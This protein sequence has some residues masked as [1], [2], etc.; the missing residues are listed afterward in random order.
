MQN[1]TLSFTEISKRFIEQLKP[2]L[3][4]KIEN[5]IY[6][7]KNNICAGNCNPLVNY[8]M[9]EPPEDKLDNE[10]MNVLRFN[11][12]ALGTGEEE[13]IFAINKKCLEEKLN[14]KYKPELFSYDEMLSR[15]RKSN[16]LVLPSFL[17][18]AFCSFF[19]SDFFDERQ[20]LALFFYNF[21]K[22]INCE[23][24]LFKRVNKFCSNETKIIKEED[25]ALLFGIKQP[26]F[27]IIISKALVQPVHS[28][29]PSLLNDMQ[30]NEIKNFI[31]EMNLHKF[32]VTYKIVR[33]FIFYNFHILY[34]ISG[35][36]YVVKKLHFKLIRTKFILDRRC[37]TDPKKIFNYYVELDKLLEEINPAFLYNFD[38]SGVDEFVDR[39]KVMGLVPSDYE[40]T[41]VHVLKSRDA[42]KIS[43]L[44]CIALDGEAIGASFI[45]HSK[46]IAD[47]LKS[48]YIFNNCHFFYSN[49]STMNNKLFLEYLQNVFIP[50]LQKKRTYYQYNGNAV[51][52]L[53]NCKSHFE[54]ESHDGILKKILVENKIILKYL[55]P[56]ATNFL[57]PLDVGTF[58][59]FKAHLNSEWNTISKVMEDVCEELDNVI[60]DDKELSSENDIDFQDPAH[61]LDPGHQ[62][63]KQDEKEFLDPLRQKNVPDLEN[64]N[65]SHDNS[66]SEEEQEKTKRKRNLKKR[67][68]MFMIYEKCNQQHLFVDP[69]TGLNESE[70]SIELMKRLKDIRRA[71]DMS[72]TYLDVI[73]AFNQTGIFCS[74]YEKCGYSYC[75][76]MKNRELQSHPE[77]LT[78]L[79]RFQ[80]RKFGE[81]SKN[82][83]NG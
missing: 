8:L 75:N 39:K 21:A 80:V 17:K 81:E 70:N 13:E 59:L 69:Y 47:K 54:P 74:N 61:F 32:L 50:H 35:V 65:H 82:S 15:A 62:N 26:T 7:M 14:P 12:T 25:I 16:N 3:S 66:S 76:P 51:L 49:T 44:A 55:P 40:G 18:I 29:R 68:E 71:Y 78:V 72:T 9:E 67:N 52:I 33:E 73:S 79:E 4:I 41:Y 20:D 10:H 53:D 6:N 48:N 24:S 46:T 22:I 28:H 60:Q 34:S 83:K 23:F 2:R 64:E 30:L 27:S 37:E 36:R 45:T 19:I 42:K 63:N 11:L 5:D 31:N 43:L 57:Q 58:G 1:N 38:E 56:L 77:I